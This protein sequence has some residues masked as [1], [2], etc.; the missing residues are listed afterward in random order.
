MVAEVIINSVVKNLNRV[1]DYNIPKELEDKVRE[2]A[3]V[4]VPFGNKKVEDAFVIG[5]KEKSDYEIKDI[6][7]FQ[8]Q[9][10]SK[11]NIELT[12][13]MSKR[14]FCNISD[15]L[16]L[17]LPPGTSTKIIENR[18][19]EKKVNFVYL[20]KKIEEIENDIN[21]KKIKSEK[22]I[23]VLEFLKN[24]EEVTVAELEICADA[25]KSII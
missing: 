7:S 24:N 17:M 22:H 10:F 1:F 12:K 4:L 5:I 21:N 3:R 25:G 23:R 9:V 11:E 15:C 13:W 16:K 19:K 18:V 20:A 8:N 6:I 14:Y 2:G